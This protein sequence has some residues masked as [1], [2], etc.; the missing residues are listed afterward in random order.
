M[1]DG[2]PLSAAPDLTI[3]AHQDDD[4]LFMQPDLIELA[5]ARGG[6]TNVYVTAGNGSGGTERADRRYRGLREAYAE[7]AGVE[8][9]W[10]C[11]WIDLAGNVA[12]HCRLDEANISL[13]FLGYPDG[14]IE[15]QLDRSLLRLWSGAI[16]GADS[17]AERST[18]YD[19]AELI[20]T[21][22]EVI[23]QTRPATIRTLDFGATHGRDHSDHMLAGA[24]TLL[25]A[26]E[27]A[28]TGQLRSFRGYAT[29]G[30]PETLIEP[31]YARSENILAHYTACVSDCAPHTCGSACDV[32][33]PEH[34]TWLHRRYAL[35]LR[36]DVRGTLRTDGGCV[37]ADASVAATC[38]ELDIAELSPAGLL[39]VGDRCL[40][41]LPS[42]EV[43]ADASCAASAHARWFLDDDGRVWNGAPP[44]PESVAPSRHLACLSASGDRLRV[45][46]CGD[47]L[48]PRWELVGTASVI[49]RPAFLPSTGRAIRGFGDRVYA[50]AGGELWSATWTG[51]SFAAPADEG[52]LP[53]EPE[54]L[55][56]G[57]LDG[58]PRACGRDAE[59]ILCRALDV[60][61]PAAERWTPAFARTGAATAGDRS[62]A[63]AGDEICGLG[64]EGVMCAPRGLTVV[65]GVRSRWPS[66]DGALWA[67][68]LDGDQRP[69]WCTATA[70][71][72]ACGRD[73]DRPLTT[74]GVPWSYALGGV[75][76]PAPGSTA[77]GVLHDLDADGRQDLCALRD[78]T[79]WC[80][81][82]QGVALGPQVSLG[83][84]PQAAPTA[85][86]FVAD[87]ACVDDGATLA[88]LPVPWPARR[89][90]P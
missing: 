14:G 8:S 49:D 48:A 81:H 32:I 18:R 66:V 27:A 84:F 74:D 59:G 70:S 5:E 54:S 4:L 16:D 62:L 60:P 63:V 79:V 85:L 56:V 88:C 80:A 2:A 51:T 89:V 61:G 47:G 9:V 65:P 29:E 35:G 15:G 33:P 44:P 72:V 50:I 24:I 42:G 30:E 52:L 25:G 3:V 71:G 39:R 57:M 1:P 87:R 55:A 58:S 68:D 34:E 7:A 20:A 90:D 10:A 28:F 31:L 17:V 67:G 19:Q 82:S 64:D 86:F 41:A 78:G 36:R 75:V 43:S 76:E 45:A 21:V 23:R 12:Q 69:D 83:A 40:A 73:L 22:A 26:G 37:R 38:G 77:L 46:P 53:V 6:L 11:G 13:V